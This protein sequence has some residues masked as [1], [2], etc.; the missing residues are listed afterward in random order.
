[1]AKWSGWE[2]LGGV[3]SSAPGA[4]SWGPNRLDVFVAGTDNQLW[5]K[6][7]DGS[8]WIGYEPLGEQLWSGPCAYSRAENLIDVFI[9]G[10]D[11]SIRQRNWDGNAWSGWFNLGQWE[12]HTPN[13]DAP[14]A[15]SYNASSRLLVFGRGADNRMY[16]K[17]WN[18]T[19]WFDFGPASA[20][21]VMSTPNIVSW[22]PL[23]IDIFW[24]TPANTVQH[25]WRHNG[26]AGTASL[27]GIVI[28]AP[29]A[30]TWGPNRLDVFVRGANNH[31][32]HK[33]TNDG[34]VTWDGWE[35]LG[36]SIIS[37][38]AAVSW[39][40]DRI[41]VFVRGTDNQLWHKYWS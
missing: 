34:G 8:K 38:P 12:N 16:Y 41:D 5:H 33:W 35:D 13:I 9:P 31:L 36:G 3:L 30:S 22:G 7:W 24:R 28:D 21:D 39:G 26:P 15:A 18:G 1:M 4:S 11:G 2:S 29:A 14:S 25:F 20:A 19:G 40:P 32:Y 37:A 17:A 10:P 23:N 6:W 27:G